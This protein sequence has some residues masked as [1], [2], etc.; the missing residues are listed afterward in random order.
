MANLIWPTEATVARG[1]F[2]ADWV[3]GCRGS[4][5]G[6][7]PIVQN[8]L[9]PSHVWIARIERLPQQSLDKTFLLP[10]TNKQMRLCAGRGTGQTGLED[11]ILARPWLQLS[12][13]VL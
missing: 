11:H 5:S 6:E 2:G 8:G 3:L 4:L 10:T 1:S 9:K 7:T 13:V 12:D